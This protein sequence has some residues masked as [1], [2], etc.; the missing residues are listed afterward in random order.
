MSETVATLK[1]D[2]ST[3]TRDYNDL[4]TRSEGTEA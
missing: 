4:K 1:T 2:I 3:W